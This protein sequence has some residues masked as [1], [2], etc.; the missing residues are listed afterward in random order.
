MNKIEMLGVGID[1]LAFQE[2]LRKVSD[3]LKEKKFHQLTVLNCANFYQFSRD[4]IFK[5]IYKNSDLTIADSKF[6]VL[7]SRMLKKP[8]KEQIA[9]ADLL[10]EILELAEEQGCRVF[11]LKGSVA[12]KDLGA[13]GLLLKKFKSLKVAGIYYTFYDFNPEE[14]FQENQRIV[15]A[16]QQAKP[17]ILI[18]SLG[19]PK[20]TKWIW[21]N[22]SY[23]ENISFCSEIGEAIDF[24]SGRVRRAPLWMQKLCLEW[25][26]RLCLEPRR[27]WKRNTVNNSYF[28]WV[29]TK[30]L[31]SSRIKQ[32]KLL[33]WRRS[34]G[35]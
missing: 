31:F 16:I 11:L 20:G 35:R 12:A 17:D 9:G 21:H 30:E 2:A 34:S 7:V 26:F 1:N 19:S 23:L 25:F 18:V 22:R 13:K 5:E 3:F 14:D 6:I 27:L 15:K 10:G 4:K 24:V 28:L 8:L 29:L 33:F 32:I